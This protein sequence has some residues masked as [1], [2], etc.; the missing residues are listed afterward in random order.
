MVN[1][2]SNKEKVWMRNNLFSQS[3]RLLT[4][5]A[6]LIALLALFMGANRLVASE[7]PC[8]EY[9]VKA[10]FLFNFAKYID[11]PADAFS[12]TNTPIVIGVLGENKIGEKLNEFVKGK[13]VNGHEIVVRR[14]EKDSDF[15][16]CHILFISGSEKKILPDILLKA[17]GKP[18]LTV[19]ETDQFIPQGGIINFI[20]KEGKIRLEI[21]IDSAGRSRLQISSKLL[22]VAD[23]VRAKK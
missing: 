16:Q 13:D 9:Q 22:S 5:V 12:D 2:K 8:S 7:A 6:G 10:L 20:K 18:V 3:Q 11:W 4:N 14:I 19:G 23:V 1:G 21:N 17:K 15:S